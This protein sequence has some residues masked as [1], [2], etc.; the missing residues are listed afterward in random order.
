[1]LRRATTIFS[2][3]AAITLANAQSLQNEAGGAV[4]LSCQAHKLYDEKQFAQSAQLYRR[5]V[6]LGIKSSDEIYYAACALARSGGSSP[7]R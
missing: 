1:M 5:A 3:A 2:L 7:S 4:A 6:E